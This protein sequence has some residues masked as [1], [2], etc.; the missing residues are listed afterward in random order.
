MERDFK[1]IWIPKEVWIKYNIQIATLAAAYKEDPNLLSKTEIKY[2]KEKGILVRTEY[3][4]TKIKDLISSKIAQRGIGN[5]KC[6]WCEGD[7]VILHEHHYPIPKKYGGLETV[8]ICPNC[9][10]EFHYL[11]DYKYKLNDEVLNILKEGE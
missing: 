5:K 6:E 10:Y 7:T 3:T 9:H 4:T 2:L 1:G 11:M 8:S